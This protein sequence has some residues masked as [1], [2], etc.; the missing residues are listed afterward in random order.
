[1]VLKFEP[2]VVSD[3]MLRLVLHDTLGTADKVAWACTTTTKLS[4]SALRFSLAHYR[5]RGQHTQRSADSWHDAK[6]GALLYWATPQLS[7]SGTQLGALQYWS[8]PW[9]S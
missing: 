8:T 6:L 1:M 5:A 3:V 9:H 2:E 4:H 7:S